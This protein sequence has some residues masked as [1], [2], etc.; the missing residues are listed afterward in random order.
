M[1]PLTLISFLG[2]VT[3][4][5]GLWCPLIHVPLAGNFSAF[6]LNQPY[7][8][9]LLLMTVIGIIGNVF[10]RYKVVQ[11]A[12]LATL[13]LVAV[14]YIAVF[15]RVKTAFSFIPFNSLAQTLTHA[16]IKFKWGWWVLVTG[17]LLALAGVRKHKA[18]N[19]F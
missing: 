2:F 8:L 16:I 12:A 14:F 11:F 4:M 6:R 9:V 17:Q 18:K 19:I 7:G 15:M 10:N 3:L 13:V 1:R 5:A